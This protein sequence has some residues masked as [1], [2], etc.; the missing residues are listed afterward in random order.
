MVRFLVLVIATT[1]MLLVMLMFTRF[2]KKITLAVKLILGVFVL[3]AVSRL[4]QD[5][6][7]LEELMPLLIALAGFG[8]VWAFFWAW[9]NWNLRDRQRRAARA[10]RGLA[11]TASEPRKA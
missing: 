10:A 2:W 4:W 8:A 7:T 6:K 9:G 3:S 5:T 1:S 11:D